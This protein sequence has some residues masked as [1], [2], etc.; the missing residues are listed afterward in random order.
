MAMASQKCLLS[1]VLPCH[2]RLINISGRW[3]PKLA[4]T[5]YWPSTHG[6]VSIQQDQEF[7]V[8]FLVARANIMYSYGDG[9]CKRKWKEGITKGRH[10]VYKGRPALTALTVE[11]LKRQA[12]PAA[13]KKDQIGHGHRLRGK[14]C[15]MCKAVNSR[16]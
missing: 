4:G 12:Q 13:K 2:C 16:E 1:E 5:G 9:I 7:Q 14:S 10:G 6:S 8:V 15:Q 11:M 3:P